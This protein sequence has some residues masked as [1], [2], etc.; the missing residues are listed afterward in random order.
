MISLCLTLQEYICNISPRFCILKSFGKHIIYSY[1]LYQLCAHLYAPDRKALVLCVLYVL[2][3]LCGES[4]L[5][6]IEKHKWRG[7]ITIVS[8][9]R[10]S[11]TADIKHSSRFSMKLC[12]LDELQEKILTTRQN[13][14]NLFRKT[15]NINLI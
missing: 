3:V 4:I 6:H 9:Q 11:F 7:S 14:R 1:Y 10:T 2:W 5:K 8:L 15:S 13:R 12:E